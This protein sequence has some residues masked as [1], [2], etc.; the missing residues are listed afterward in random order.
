M[1]PPG[2]SQELTSSRFL[3]RWLNLMLKCIFSFLCT[4][5]QERA[6]L[7]SPI[8]RKAAMGGGKYEKLVKVF[9]LLSYLKCF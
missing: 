4:S 8:V 1:L 3:V 7:K 2:V 5:T 9:P 6:P